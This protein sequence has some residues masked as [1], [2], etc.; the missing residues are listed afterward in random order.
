MKKRILPLKN[1]RR[2]QSGMEKKE[3]LAMLLEA[4]EISQP[5]ISLE[6][7][8][9]GNLTMTEFSIVNPI[10]MINSFYCMR[11]H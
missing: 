4:W 2:Y 1:I 6:E 10:S 9:S 8:N 11:K 7:I 5:G 3:L